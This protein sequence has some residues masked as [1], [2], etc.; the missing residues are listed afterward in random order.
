[1]KTTTI[2]IERTPMTIH[3]DGQDINVEELSIRL[4]FGRKP[5][6]ITNIAATG[7]NK[8]YV[9]ETIELTS[10]E[11]DCFANA[12]YKSHDWLKNK[13]GYYES[14]RLCVEVTAPG[15]PIL[16]IDPSGSD[17]PRYVARLG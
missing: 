5:S 2:V 17:Y 11:F 7:N 13:G 9:T 10:A 15:R 16:F 6:D 12:L 8:V 14:G 4:P 3:F 1:M